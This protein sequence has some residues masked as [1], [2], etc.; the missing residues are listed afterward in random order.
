MTGFE[1]ITTVRMIQIFQGLTTTVGL[2]FAGVGIGVVFGV[3]F[4]VLSCRRLRYRA[5]SRLIRIYVFVIQGTP[6]YVQILLIYFALPELWGGSLSSIFAGIIA[7]GANSVAYVTQIVRAG[8]NSVS[9]GQWEAAFALGYSVPSAL[10]YVILPQ[11]LRNVLP[12]LVNEIISLVK[13]TS[14]LGVI[15]VLELTKVARD[16]VN[17]TMEPL[18]WYVIAA[19]LYLLITSLLNLYA[20]R[21]ER[22]LEYDYRH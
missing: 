2:A 16:T 12:A 20:R 18:V 5:V 17:R 1:S 19:V 8:I 3:L 11:M 10:W 4:G 22:K 14:I 6:L 13:E 9:V 15:G 7:L 21:L